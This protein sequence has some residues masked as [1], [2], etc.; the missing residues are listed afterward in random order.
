MRI[1]EVRG[2]IILPCFSEAPTC[3]STTAWLEYFPSGPDKT[4]Q[5]VS[6]A[7]GDQRS[8]LNLYSHFLFQP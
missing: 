1:L 5:G 3:M 4:L 6:E 2:Y 7:R 8:I